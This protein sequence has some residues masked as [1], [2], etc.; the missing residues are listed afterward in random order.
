M[1]VG[2]LGTKAPEHAR[3]TKVLPYRTVAIRCH[4]KFMLL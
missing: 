2:A 4:E 1:M 3:R